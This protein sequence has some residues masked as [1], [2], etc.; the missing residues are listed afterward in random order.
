MALPALLLD[1]L[2]LALGSAFPATWRPGYMYQLRIYS[3]RP[4]S[5]TPLL[6]HFVAA[7]RVS[8]IPNVCDLFSSM[9]L[10]F[11]LHYLIYFALLHRVKK[12]GH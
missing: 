11:H 1:P 2:L 6:S 5:G 4:F 12:M 3:Y 8:V 7:F 10:L 9:H